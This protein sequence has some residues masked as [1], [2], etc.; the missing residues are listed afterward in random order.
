MSDASLNCAVAV[1][2][3]ADALS[4]FH[5]NSLTWR[6]EVDG[7]SVITICVLS[8]DARLAIADRLG[9]GSVE[10]T[11][12]PLA[13]H[14]GTWADMRVHVFGDPSDAEMDAYALARVAS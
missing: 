13:N 11:P 8:P 2:L 12:R 6:R 3:I 5:F 4:P 10:I 14:H 7:V 1:H 9:L